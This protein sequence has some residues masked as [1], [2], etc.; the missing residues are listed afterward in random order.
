MT[1]DPQQAPPPRAGEART[2]RRYLR[3]FG[4]RTAADLDDEL[5]FHVEMRVRDYMASGMSEAD[6]RSAT[7]QFHARSTIAATL[8]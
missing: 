3:F 6:A 1:P 4:P 2:W 7:A 5:R 8:G